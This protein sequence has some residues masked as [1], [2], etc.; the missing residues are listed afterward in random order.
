MTNN[1]T[2]TGDKK[3]PPWQPRLLQVFQTGLLNARDLNTGKTKYQAV[4]TSKVHPRMATV[5]GL[6]WKFEMPVNDL[7]PV[8]SLINKQG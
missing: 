6:T 1:C 3:A 7:R 4:I 2:S 8:L 5:R